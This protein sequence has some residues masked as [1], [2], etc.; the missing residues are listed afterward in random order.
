[1]KYLKD[2]ADA[3]KNKPAKSMAQRVIIYTKLCLVCWFTKCKTT[4]FELEKNVIMD[5]KK[6]YFLFC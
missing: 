3:V 5:D 4:V 1:M 6:R 2:V